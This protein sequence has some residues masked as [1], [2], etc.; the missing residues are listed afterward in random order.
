MNEGYY[1]VLHL[2]DV[3]K[4]KEKMNNDKYDEQ[5]AKALFCKPSIKQ[6]SDRVSFS[7]FLNSNHSLVENVLSP[8]T[9][10]T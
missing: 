5:F 1:K 2:L 6:I 10:Y 7:S 4:K 9:P 8:Y 3:W